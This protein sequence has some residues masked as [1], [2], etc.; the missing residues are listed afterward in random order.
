MVFD[1]DQAD[2]RRV[3]QYIDTM[4]RD[5]KQMAAGAGLGMVAYLLDMVSHEV[6]ETIGGLSAAEPEP[7]SRGAARARSRQ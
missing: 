6:A 7:S 4:A 1:P 3:A 2:R 5:L